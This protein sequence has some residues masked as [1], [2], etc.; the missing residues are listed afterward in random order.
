MHKFFFNI[1]KLLF[2]IDNKLALV[3]R[4]ADVLFK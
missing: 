3:L 1:Y 2:M 4:I